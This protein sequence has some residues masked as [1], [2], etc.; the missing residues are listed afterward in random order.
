MSAPDDTIAAAVLRHADQILMAA[1][2]GPIAT[3]GAHCDVILDAVTDCYAQGYRAGAHHAL[4]LL[5]ELDA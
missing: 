5:K 3:A 1:G 2:L 4:S